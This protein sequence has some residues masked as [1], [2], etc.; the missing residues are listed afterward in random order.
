MDV[1]KLDRKLVDPFHQ[2]D[3]RARRLG[4]MYCERFAVIGEAIF[5]GG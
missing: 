2:I 1:G 4:R 3:D 5:F